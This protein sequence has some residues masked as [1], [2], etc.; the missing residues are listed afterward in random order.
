MHVPMCLFWFAMY[1]IINKGDI[2]EFT[3]RNYL[4]VISS[5]KGFFSTLFEQSCLINI[6]LIWFNVFLPIYPADGGRYVGSYGMYF[7]IYLFTY[8]NITYSYF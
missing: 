6:L 5:S 1:A 8:T 2:S 3:F 4:T 7:F